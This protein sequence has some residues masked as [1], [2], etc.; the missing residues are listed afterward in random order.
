MTTYGA[1]IISR[2]DNYGN[3]LLE[4]ATYCLNSMAEVLDEIVYVDWN[5]DNDKPTM[6]EEIKDDLVH[7]EKIRWV[8]V[9]QEQAREW[10]WNDP[11]AQAVCETQARNVGLR[12]LST[13]FLISA[14]IDIIPPQRKHLE[15]V[16]NT[17]TFFTTGMRSISLYDLRPLGDRTRP[18][19]Y[20]TALEQ[21]ESRYSQQPPTSVHWN[22]RFSLVSNCGD[23]QIAHKDIWYAMRGFEER[24][25]G[26]AYMDSNVQMKATLV[27][28][29]IAVDW[30]LPIWHIGHDAG[31]GGSGK[32]NNIDEAFTMK[33]TTNPETWGHID[34]GLEIHE[35]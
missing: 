34:A 8:R 13:D 20:I 23:F 9:T 29:N 10:T 18:D 16:I 25:T 26:R 12:R 3:L 22:D 33:E 35:L 1:S 6:I 5:T 27:G 30:S 21:L 4:R 2:N 11:Q 32:I 7:K 31:F 28:Y 14:N 24:F 15:R 17:S 19:I